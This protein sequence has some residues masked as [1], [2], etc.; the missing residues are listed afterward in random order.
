[1][2]LL[3]SL[4]I[5][6]LSKS[7]ITGPVMFHKAFE[8]NINCFSFIIFEQ[9][10]TL[11]F[12]KNRHKVKLRHRLDLSRIPR[13]TQNRPCLSSKFKFHNLNKVLHSKN[14]LQ[15]MTCQRL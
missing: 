7:N 10:G 14:Q 15:Y 12:L 13:L 2:S 8:T 5:T 6:N 9:V 11:Y 3:S 1:M 4:S